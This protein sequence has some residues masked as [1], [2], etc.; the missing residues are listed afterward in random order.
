M[1]IKQ[2]IG[3]RQVRALQL[4]NANLKAGSLAGAFLRLLM[5]A[6]KPSTP[7]KHRSSYTAH[8]RCRFGR[9]PAKRAGRRSG[10]AVKPLNST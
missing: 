3:L 5:L 6:H 10:A 2:R 9:T 7:S 1:A 8:R 4:P